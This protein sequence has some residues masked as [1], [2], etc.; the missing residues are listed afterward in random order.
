M[1]IFIL[2]LIVSMANEKFPH[3]TN[4]LWHSRI[5]RHKILHRAYRLCLAL[6]YVH[7]FAQSILLFFIFRLENLFFVKSWI[8]RMVSLGWEW[9]KSQMIIGLNWIL[10]D[11]QIR[12]FSNFSL[13][14]LL[15]KDPK[16]Y[17]TDHFI[18][19]FHLQI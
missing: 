18:S 17:F 6:S 19:K 15:C 3:K 9:I 13:T 1:L 10:Y 5:M 4:S 2:Q 16:E 12:E 7:F 14:K 11:N 8:M